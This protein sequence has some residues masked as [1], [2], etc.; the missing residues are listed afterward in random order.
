MAPDNILLL[1]SG[2]PVLLDFG[3]ARHVVRGQAQ[4]L[5]AVLKPSYAPIEQYAADSEVHQGPWTDIYAVAATLHYSLT[6]KAPPTSAARAV[7][8]RHL[9]LL[10]RQEFGAT[11]STPGYDSAWLGALDWGLAVMPQARPQN[12]AQWRAALSGR[13]PVPPTAIR[14]VDR[15]K[16]RPGSGAWVAAAGLATMVALSLAGGLGSPRADR[17]A[18][19]PGGADASA[20]GAVAVLAAVQI[21]PA[22]AVPQPLQPSASAAVELAH[23]PVAAAL[24]KPRAVPAE[25][26]ARA[27]RTVKKVKPAATTSPQQLCAKL[28][29][30]SRFNCIRKACATPRWDR[31]PQCRPGA[32]VGQID[33]LP[34]ASWRVVTSAELPAPA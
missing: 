16:A 8:D 13:W 21:D 25:A 19:S 2:R 6:G 26:R 29:W 9:P 3:A 14:P 11:S 22:I 34:K 27:S 1:P 12:I 24:P 18:P 20:P 30:F 15:K 32:R 17:P 33:A 5:T 23:E 28:G 4:A 31:H 7:H 10:S